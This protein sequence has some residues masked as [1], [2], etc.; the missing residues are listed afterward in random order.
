M[1][2]CQCVHVGA[3][4]GWEW[5]ADDISTLSQFDIDIDLDKKILT[6]TALLPQLPP[7]TLLLNLDHNKIE[8]KAA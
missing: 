3:G 7:P 2:L 5:F 1:Q 6:L 4:G 8:N